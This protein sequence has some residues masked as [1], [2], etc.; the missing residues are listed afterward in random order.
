MALSDI[1]LRDA[2]PR[3]LI[4]E[5]KKPILQAVKPSLPEP[6]PTRPVRMM[7]RSL[8]KAA[9]RA[10]AAKTIEEI[11]KERTRRFGVKVR[12]GDVPGKVRVKKRDARGNVILDAQG[13]PIFEEKPVDLNVLA[14]IL[15]SGTDE[16]ISKLD[17]ISSAIAAGQAISQQDAQNMIIRLMQVLSDMEALK[18]LTAT[19]FA[20][21]GQALSAAGIP[22]N[23]V[24]AGITNIIDGRFIT[25][26]GWKA[27]GG[28]NRTNILL[29]LMGRASDVPGLSSEKPVFGIR[30]IHGELQPVQVARLI[31]LMSGEDRGI[32]FPVLDLEARRIFRSLPEARVAAGFPVDLSVV[33]GPR[34]L[35][36]PDEKDEKDEKIEGFVAPT[37]EI[38]LGRRAPEEEDILTRL[39]RQAEEAARQEQLAQRGTLVPFQPAA[40]EVE[41][42]DP[43]AAQEFT[44][45]QV[46]LLRQQ[47]L[48]P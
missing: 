6:Q 29:F 35:A 11:Q 9:P 27:D 40:P 5:R 28:N 42:V 26:S 31:V 32:P 45:E 22:D 30:I 7:R 34:G 47:G 46:R 38:P 44:D 48:L 33:P 24:Q 16:N 18:N 13:Q 43:R 36:T 1:S 20:V 8:K 25:V 12:I 3:F 37:T 19:Q 14:N 41:V 2:R 21:I 23:P 10:R 39:A 17:Q 15:S 4:G